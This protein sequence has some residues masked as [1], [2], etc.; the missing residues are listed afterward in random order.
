LRRDPQLA[1]S[2]K[3]THAPVR[4][5]SS[6]LSCFR[7]CARPRGRGRRLRGPLPAPATEPV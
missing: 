5:A 2:N 6:V 4:A 7:R 3:D 1:A